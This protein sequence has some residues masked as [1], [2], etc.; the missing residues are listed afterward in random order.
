MNVRPIYFFLL[1]LAATF[2]YAVFHAGQ[3]K[4]FYIYRQVRAELTPALEQ[5][6]LAWGSPVYIRIFKEEKQL[7]VWM[8]DNG[9]YELFAT[10]PVCDY[11][12]H[13]GPKLSEGDRQAPEGFYSVTKKQMVPGSAFHLSFDLGFPNEYDRMNGRTGS[14]LMVHGGCVS[15]GCYA[16]TDDVIDKV[17]SLLAA[18][19]EN[20]QP[21]VSVHIF[22]FRL[23]EEN[24][25]KHAGAR[26][27]AWWH[28]LKPGYD[29][30]ESTHSV[31]AITVKNGKYFLAE[32]GR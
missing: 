27:V 24:I 23:N 14:H 18:A 15:A 10:Y 26:W 5:K 21:A 28:E 8:E 25:R 20:G 32:A 2:V 16:M 31:P 17:F 13:L 30:F 19:F 12:G 11:S 9:Q 6:H 1:L 3:I 4:S 22:P 29:F 7:E